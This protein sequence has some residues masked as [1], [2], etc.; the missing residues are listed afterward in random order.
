[1]TKRNDLTQ[2][3]CHRTWFADHGPLVKSF[4]GILGMAKYVQSHAIAPEWNARVV[5]A[6]FAPPLDGITEVWTGGA[7]D[8]ASDDDTAKAA[9]ALVEDRAE[10][11]RD[12]CVAL[13]PDEGAHD[14]RSHAISRV[15]NRSCVRKCGLATSA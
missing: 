13:L 10:V 5:T 4:A 2:E 1:M 7:R 6:G 11:R 9:M 14:L 8:T 15:A 12:G 3:A